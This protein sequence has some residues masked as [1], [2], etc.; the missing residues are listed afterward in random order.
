L[1]VTKGA[2]GVSKKITVTR[3]SLKDSC[4]KSISCYILLLF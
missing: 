1:F 2:E 3:E 4:I